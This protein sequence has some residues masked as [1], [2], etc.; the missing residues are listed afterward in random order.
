MQ[1][2]Y[3]Y[4]L[5]HLAPEVGSLNDTLRQ[6]KLACWL[7][8]A[9]GIC[10]PRARHDGV[11]SLA[12]LRNLSVPILGL[13]LQ[14]TVAHAQLYSHVHSS[15]ASG[16]QEALLCGSSLAISPVLGIS[17]FIKCCNDVTGCVSRWFCM[18]AAC[19]SLSLPH[20]STRTISN[21]SSKN[22]LWRCII[23]ST[24]LDTAS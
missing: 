4:L 11:I 1:G 14:Q 6:L 5:S 24:V 23:F 2:K 12:F 13:T 17:S 18:L 15:T 3:F 8:C 22:I 16:L 7:L 20:H 10:D 9:H 21:R 19:D